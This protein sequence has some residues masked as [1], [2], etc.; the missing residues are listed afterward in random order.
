MMTETTRQRRPDANKSRYRRRPQ[1]E[2]LEGRILLNAGALD[3]SFGGTGQVIT[4]W[5]HGPS[6]RGWPFSPTSRRS[7]WGSSRPAAAYPYNL[8]LFRYNVD[9]SL[10]S[11]FGSGGEVVLAT[12]SVWSAYSQHTASVAIQPDGKIVVATNTA[13]REQ[14]GHSHLVRYAG[15]A[16]QPGREPRHVLRSERPDRHPPAAGDGRGQRHRRPRQRPDRRGGN[17]PVRLQSAP[18][19]S[20][21]A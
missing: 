19:S 21:P 3:T 8:T 5:A 4:N 16:V 15:P 12:N 1:V 14:R 10:D 9:G 6:P 7:W 11:T 20:S 17:E 13:T 18:S 2:P